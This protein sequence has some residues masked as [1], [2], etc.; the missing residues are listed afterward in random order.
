MSSPALLALTMEFLAAFKTFIGEA[1]TL[2]GDDS[3]HPQTW[4]PAI[5]SIERC[6]NMAGKFE[7]NLILKTGS[8]C[9]VL[10]HHTRFLNVGVIGDHGLLGEKDRGDQGVNPQV[11]GSAFGKGLYTGWDAQSHSAASIADR[12]LYSG[13]SRSKP[14]YGDCAVVCIAHLGI[15]ERYQ[16]DKE[17]F[18]FA[19]S[20]HA[21]LPQS[22]TTLANK[23][24]DLTASLQ[25]PHQEA[26]IRRSLCTV[27]WD[28]KQQ[29]HDEVILKNP[30]AQQI[31]LMTLHPALLDIG[32]NASTAIKTMEKMI[33]QWVE[34]FLIP[35]CCHTGYF[36]GITRG[37]TCGAEQ[38]TVAVSLSQAPDMNNIGPL[39][40]VGGDTPKGRSD[41]KYGDCQVLNLGQYPEDTD[42]DDMNADELNLAHVIKAL[43]RQQLRQ[44]PD[45]SCMFRAL[46]TCFNM[47]P[48]TGHRQVRH[49][50][51]MFLN[52]HKQALLKADETEWTTGKD[53][54]RVTSPAKFDKW[55]VNLQ[56]PNAWGNEHVL[57][58]ASVL[59]N[60]HIRVLRHDG[61]IN[62][63]FK[64]GDISWAAEHLTNSRNTCQPLQGVTLGFVSHDYAH[65]VLVVPQSQNVGSLTRHHPSDWTSDDASATEQKSPPSNKAPTRTDLH[66]LVLISHHLAPPRTDL[67]LTSD[68]LAPS[69]TDLA[70]PE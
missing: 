5:A 35:A 47:C 49:E 29:A 58:A 13:G 66:H 44:K 7:T 34:E 50:I 41:F 30:Q 48:H 15:V 59:Y 70:P 6:E 64:P 37:S 23:W 12:H 54:N 36:T 9:D 22:R 40:P 43:G 19:V 10:Y 67:T 11:A 4:M 25:E 38:E 3:R 61:I 1:A 26:E 39:L 69:H 63:S 53:G 17:P 21:S 2:N 46:A 14:D 18:Q 56:K 28:G 20:A 68:R 51:V 57:M 65:Y 42:D 60:A 62:P 24:K 32:W 33:K 8:L 45:G 52:K 31:T 16:L 27:R 55:L